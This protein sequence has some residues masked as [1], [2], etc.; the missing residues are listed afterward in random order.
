[1][2]IKRKHEL[3]EGGNCICPKCETIVLHKS[4]TPCNETKCPKCDAKMLRENSEHHKALLKKR[5][6]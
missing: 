2:T 6:K 4:G 5:S 1:M 3:G